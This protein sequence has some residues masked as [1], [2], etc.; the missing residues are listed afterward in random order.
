MKDRRFAAAVERFL[1]YLRDQRRLSPQTLRA[2]RS[3]LAQFG[4]YLADLAVSDL[5]G[6]P[7]ADPELSGDA[8]GVIRRFMEFHL[9]RRFS[10][11]AVLGS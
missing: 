2:Y 10:S 11:L 1:D 5:N 8:M 4:R 9:E 6:L 3:D 7:S